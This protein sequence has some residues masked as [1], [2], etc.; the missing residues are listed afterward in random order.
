MRA[1]GRCRCVGMLRKHDCAMNGSEVGFRF[2]RISRVTNSNAEVL[3][4]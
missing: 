3:H 2:E 1:C 4:L